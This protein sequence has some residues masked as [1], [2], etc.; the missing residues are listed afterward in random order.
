MINCKKKIQGMQD[1]LL[2]ITMDKDK[3]NKQFSLDTI[4]PFPFKK[5]LFMPPFPKGL[6]IPKYDKYL[7]TSNPHDHLREF[8]ALSMEFM[9]D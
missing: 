8:G 2:K 5:G 3:P 1:L 6:E 7:G 4:C 9:H